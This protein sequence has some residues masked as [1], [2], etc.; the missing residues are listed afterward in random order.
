[1]SQTLTQFILCLALTTISNRDI[2]RGTHSPW[3]P[4]FSCYRPSVVFLFFLL[5]IKITF[6]KDALLFCCLLQCAI[7][8]R[9]LWMWAIALSVLVHISV[10]RQ[11]AQ[12]V[13]AGSL[14][15]IGQGWNCRGWATALHSRSHNSL[16]GWISSPHGLA[17]TSI[18]GLLFHSE[19][20]SS[21]SEKCIWNW[22]GT[23]QI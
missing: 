15:Q 2:H 8:A 7:W 14:W 4:L 22:V 17:V 6:V 5:S 9:S 20:Y 21:Q 12:L 10:C 13:S 18:H 23:R 11:T 16:N 1:M 19:S 3:L